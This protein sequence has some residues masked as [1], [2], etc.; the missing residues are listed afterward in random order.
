MGTHQD[1]MVWL[2]GRHW[3]GNMRSIM[4]QKYL[5]DLI[6]VVDAIIMADKLEYI[7]GRRRA[8]GHLP[9]HTSIGHHMLC[10]DDI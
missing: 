3:D 5:L 10:R 8:Y 9:I 1:H 4:H 6:M 7:T 2:I